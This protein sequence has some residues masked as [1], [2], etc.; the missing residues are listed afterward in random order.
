MF[1]TGIMKRKLNADWTESG[2]YVKYM[3]SNTYKSIVI[4][5]FMKVQVNTLHFLTLL[6]LITTIS[7]IYVL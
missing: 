1:Q 3:I 4:N 5:L 2:K 7:V 6:C